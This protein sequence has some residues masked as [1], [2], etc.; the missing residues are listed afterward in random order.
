LY[1]TASEEPAMLP[2]SREHPIPEP[3]RVTILLQKTRSK[4]ITGL[5]RLLAQWH[6]IAA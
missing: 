1:I 6:S 4:P 3:G 2:E 5:D